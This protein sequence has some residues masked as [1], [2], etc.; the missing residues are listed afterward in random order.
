QKRVSASLPRRPDFHLFH[1]GRGFRR[2]G[3]LHAQ[4][5]LFPKSMPQGR[6]FSR[7]R[8]RINRLLVYWSTEI[9][10]GI[11]AGS[12]ARKLR[13]APPMAWGPKCTRSTNRLPMSLPPGAPW[14]AR[15]LPP[16]PR[17]ALSDPTKPLDS[18]GYKGVRNTY[19]EKL[20][21]AVA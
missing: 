18:K 16:H 13:F 17:R 19:G 12:E 8:C 11:L 1:D 14:K 2:S 15:L 10:R 20:H 21:S 9:E 6:P 7:V 3:M 4:G 5:R